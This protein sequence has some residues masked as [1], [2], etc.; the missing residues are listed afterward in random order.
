MHMS[1]HERPERS[2]LDLKSCS[3]TVQGKWLLDNDSS[4]DNPCEV[5]PRVQLTS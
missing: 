2:K 1:L 3:S 5:S 4:A